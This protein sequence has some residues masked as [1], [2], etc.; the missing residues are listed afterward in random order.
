M[1]HDYK[2]AICFS[3]KPYVSFSGQN[4]DKVLTACFGD[5]DSFWY[6]SSEN[7]LESIAHH[8]PP[9]RLLIEPDVPIDMHGF[10]TDHLLKTGLQAF[11]QQI[12]GWKRSNEMRKSYED[13]SG[14]HYDLVVRCRPDI[15]FRAFLPS[16][17]YFDPRMITVPAFSSCYGYNDRFAIGNR[18][19]MDILMNFFGFVCKNP[20]YLAASNAETAFKKYLEWFSIPVFESNN[21]GFDR[22]RYSAGEYVIQRDC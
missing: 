14:T 3:G 15:L 10:P 8:L 16:I 11:L 22:V 13:E 7:E 21:I 2:V 20:W 6:L 19:N 5:Y 12:H 9:T 17:D 1:L 4:L 18:K